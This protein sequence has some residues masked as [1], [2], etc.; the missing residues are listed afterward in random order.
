MDFL[1][2]RPAVMDFAPQIGH[3]AIRSFVMGERSVDPTAEP[4][5]EELTAMA[6]VVQEAIE[7]GAAGL[8]STF[9]EI[10]QDVHGN[11]VPGCFARTAECVALA[12]GAGRAGY[13]VYETAGA[14]DVAK[15]VTDGK[16]P[17]EA[18]V[19]I[20]QETTV[21]FLCNEQGMRRSL[22][23]L[24]KVNAGGSRVFGQVFNRA[25]GLLLGLNGVI[26]VF[27][28]RSPTYCKHRAEPLAQ[29]IQSLQNPI[30]R[31]A[32]LDE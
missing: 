11:N 16:H 10:H 23:W 18:L 28:V 25:Q 9:A 14:P 22:E 7:A 4:T 21:S 29:R 30:V 17:M 5:K 31:A 2:T 27:A 19:E 8:S 1:E 32:I 15:N 12:K 20:G 13:A 24:E 3:G 6:D 26:N